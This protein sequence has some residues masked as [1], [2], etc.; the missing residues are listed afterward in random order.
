MQT[1]VQNHN[2]QS[3]VQQASRQTQ[4]KNDQAM[5]M[6]DTRANHVAQR[7][8]QGLADASH[9]SVQ[10]KVFQAK[11]NGEADVAQR[12]EEE[13]PLQGKFET[14]QRVE[15]EEP[16]QGKFE[17]A[18]RVEEEE[19]LQGKFETAQRVEEEEPLQ[20]KFE[21]AQREEKAKPNNTGLPD[22]LKSGIESMSGM[23]M[24]HVKVHY[25]SDKPAQLNAHAYAQGSEIH[26]APGQEQHLPH[27]AWHVV[28]QAQGRVKPTMQMKMGVP[29]NDDVG[30]EAEADVMGAKA[31]THISVPT[32]AT[33]SKQRSTP[34]A[35][36]NIVGG[37]YEHW[38]KNV[39]RVTGKKLDRFKEFLSEVHG[40]D[41]I[42]F[43]LD[44]VNGFYDKNLAS[45]NHTEMGEDTDGKIQALKRY[46]ALVRDDEGGHGAEKHG[47]PGDQ[48]LVN[49]ANQQGGNNGF[50]ASSL[51]IDDFL[52][53]DTLLKRDADT[54]YSA[55]EGLVEEKLG[56]IQGAAT[57]AGAFT[58][59]GDARTKIR[60][61][62]GT[63]KEFENVETTSDVVPKVVLSTDIR[64]GA[65]SEEV[66][67]QKS[68]FKVPI[69]AEV[70]GLTNLNGRSV[71]RPAN[72][73]GVRVVVNLEDVVDVQ[74]RPESYTGGLSPVYEVDSS[75]K[76]KAGPDPE[77]LNWVTKY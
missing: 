6:P 76:K 41:E 12:V 74:K 44:E 59:V 24:D 45:L 28:Q 56:E 58:G 34:V 62:V 17:T 55:Y 25:N 26:V 52:Q 2:E 36:L 7:R 1:H 66:V 39:K 67:K 77:S 47:E 38:A 35:Q 4:L 60:D 23:S 37:G 68:T 63:D 48:F 29:V 61:Y 13:E 33:E 69:G 42:D 19:P 71:T 8:V 27:E 32:Q 15:E 46:A 14:A 73:G 11:M 49:R 75:G 53:W 10:L 40:I 50:T 3:Q 9:N 31:M 20:G 43:T 22:Q 57:N 30:L 5:Q 51:N 21:T 54:I 18:Q 65:I 64:Y 16:L 72:V 70:L